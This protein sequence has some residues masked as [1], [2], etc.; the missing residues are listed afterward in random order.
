MGRIEDPR[1]AQVFLM[2]SRGMPLKAA[3]EKCGNP[4][5]WANVQ[6]RYNQLH[7]PPIAAA[8]AAASSQPSKRAREM[9]AAAGAASPPIA[10]TRAPR[11]PGAAQGR[12]GSSLQQPTPASGGSSEKSSTRVGDS[13]QQATRRSSKEVETSKQNKL[14]RRAA[15]KAAHKGA[16]LEMA[17]AKDSGKQKCRGFTAQ[18]IATK[19]DN[20]L[21]PDNPHT[22]TPKALL[23]WSR[24]GKTPGSSPQLP[25]PKQSEPKKALV[26]ALKSYVFFSYVFFSYV[27]ILRL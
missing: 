20:T 13:G 5:T 19:Y 25:G 26:S 22:V 3:W 23:E 16:T 18:D 7:P 14:R 1:V 15:Y 21:S 8:P 9:A 6:R 11:T 10:Q 4:T 12:A 27:G 17:A 2:A 24:Q